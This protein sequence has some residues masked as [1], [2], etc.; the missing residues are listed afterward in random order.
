[1]Q[2]PFQTIAP[3]ENF[4]NFNTAEVSSSVPPTKK[5][6]NQLY[7]L[8]AL[9]AVLMIAVGLT[10]AQ[11][12]VLNN[13]EQRTQAAVNDQVNASFEVSEVSVAPG[14]SNQGSIQISYD[15]GIIPTA[16]KFILTYD[17]NALV[18][19]SIDIGKDFP[20]L[21]SPILID[22]Q[23]GVAELSVARKPGGIDIQSMEV[24]RVTYKIIEGSSSTTLQLDPASEVAV[25]GSR[26]NVLNQRTGLTIISLQTNLEAVE[27]IPPE[28]LNE[29]IEDGVSK[30]SPLASP[31]M[32]SDQQVK[33][34]T[35]PAPP[36]NPIDP[37][38]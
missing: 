34:S 31:I 36:V 8:G 33:P 12:N 4:V 19:E 38:I 18:I 20:V 3:S 37:Q 30:P 32:R 1:M 21:L 2:S 28:I 10:V 11:M 6:K 14:S 27:V 9:T 29:F 35:R 7:I 22:V 23:S 25:V 15:H 17:P 26:E 13:Q 24:A 16:A 5:S